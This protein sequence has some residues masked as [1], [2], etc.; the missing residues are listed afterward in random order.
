MKRR[1]ITVILF[2]VLAAAGSSTM[3]FRVMSSNT[4]R[5]VDAA[6]ATVLVAA[7]DLTPGTL[8][9]EADVRETKWPITEGSPW[10]AKRQ[11]VVGRGL[12]TP[13][14]KDEPF[15]ESRLAA[16][17]AGAGLASKIPQGMRAIAVHV[18][19]LTGLSRFILAGMHV[20]VISTATSGQG[21][22]SRT[23]LQNVE[24]FSTG[25]DIQRDSKDKPIGVPVFNLLVTPQ[26]AEILS[27]AVAQT[28]IELVL[29]NPLDKVNFLPTVAAAHIASDPSP[30]AHP[31]PHPADVKPPSPPV[32]AP[33]VQ[34]P[35]T[36]EIIHGTK[37][38]V[39][40]VSAAGDPES[41]Q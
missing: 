40:T 19:E 25:Q 17:G 20:D 13:I 38:T 32:M 37:R 10:L 29:R 9:G 12:M 3:L 26:D 36:V 14:L 16:K 35:P 1:L 8:I 28:R 21:M 24:V 11:D 2:A 18:D 7:H 39:S 22:V 31:R 6:T 41:K 15:A 33:V 23:I 4:P 5:P 30:K 34:Q 27:Q